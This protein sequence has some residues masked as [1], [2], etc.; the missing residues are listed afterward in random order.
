MTSMNGEKLKEV[1]TANP[2][3]AAVFF[4]ELWRSNR[5]EVIYQGVSELDNKLDNVR[6][7][8]R[9]F[10]KEAPFIVAAMLAAHDSEFSCRSFLGE[11][12][13]TLENAQYGMFLPHVLYPKTE[14]VLRVEVDQLME[15]SIGQAYQVINERALQS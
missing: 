1:V 11:V 2:D 9:T 13:S 8:L 7:I 6:K 12:I 10:K 14:D 5:S 15:K 3:I 4:H